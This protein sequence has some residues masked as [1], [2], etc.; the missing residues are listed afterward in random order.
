MTYI[1]AI[2]I[3]NIVYNLTKLTFKLDSAAQICYNLFA[4]VLI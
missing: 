4:A 2:M 3:M 1:A